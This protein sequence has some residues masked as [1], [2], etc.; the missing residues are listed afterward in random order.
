[1]QLAGSLHLLPLITEARVVCKWLEFAKLVFVLQP[2]IANAARN[3]LRQFRIAERKPPSRGHAVG[4]V[5]KFVGVQLVK[6][7]QNGLLQQLAMQGSDAIDGVRAD[8]GKVGH[9]HVLLAL[10]VN[11]RESRNS[12]FIVRKPLTK[13]AQEAGI[14]F[15]DDLQVPRQQLR[16][17]RQR[18]FLKRL[19]QQGVICVSQRLLRDAPG[20]VPIQSVD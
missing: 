17:Q 20:S 18:P 16:K 7:M 15:E 14:N 19:R 11:Q 1:M 6:V 8:G 13:L 2:S 12:S 4:D 5:E 10:L 3:Q 9:A